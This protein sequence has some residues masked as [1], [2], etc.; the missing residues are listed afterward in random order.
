MY[1]DVTLVFICHTGVVITHKYL[2]GTLK[3]LQYGREVRS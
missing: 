2:E 1:S 3:F